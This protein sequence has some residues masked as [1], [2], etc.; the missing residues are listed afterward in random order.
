MIFHQKPATYVGEVQLKVSNLSESIRFYEEVIGLTVKDKSASQASFTTNGKDTLLTIIEPEDIQSKKGQTT[1]LYH[2]ALLLPTRADLAQVV[3]HFIQDEIRFA[4]GDHLVSEAIYLADPDGNGIE[5]YADRDPAEW[6]WQDGEVA[7]TTVAVDIEDLLQ[8]TTTDAWHGLP[9]NTVMGHIH[10][11]VNDLEENEKF[12]ID[13]LGFS[14]VNRYGDSALFISDHDY[15]HHIALNTWSSRNA[16]HAEESET[17]IHAY[18]ILFPSE[19]VRNEKIAQLKRI[20]ATIHEENGDYY[21]YDPSH[22]KLIL[23]VDT[24]N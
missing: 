17:G 8:E 16:R 4:T 24:S 3:K 7:M 10:L 20:G 14:V 18:T 11:Q 23:T 1:G 6:E 22:I 9:E 2:F 21:T 5:I 12:Y 15:H 19:E 13:G